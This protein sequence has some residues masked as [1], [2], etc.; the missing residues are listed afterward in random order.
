MNLR[1]ETKDFEAAGSLADELP[2]WGRLPD[3]ECLLGRNGNLIALGQLSP[4][5]VDGRA[6][7]HLDRVIRPL[8]TRPGPTWTTRCGFI[9]TFSAGR[10]ELPKPVTD[11]GEVVRLSQQRRGEFLAGRVSDV[12]VYVAWC[13]DAGLQAAGSEVNGGVTTWLRRWMAQR[14]KPNEVV[15]LRRAVESAAEQFRQSVAASRALVSDLTPIDLLGPQEGSRVLSELVNRPGTPWSGATGGGLNWQLAVSELEAERRFLRLD[16]EAALVYSMLSRPGR[17]QGQPSCRSFSPRCHLD[18][19]PGV[20][21]LGARFRPAKDPQRPKTLLLKALLH[22]RPHAG[23]PGNC[24]RHDRHRRRGGIKPTWQRP[25]RAGGRWHLLRFHHLH[26]YPP[27]RLSPNR[28]A[29]CPGPPHLQHL[30]R[31]GDPRRI[32]PAPGMV[33]PAAR[34][35]AQAAASAASLHPPDCWPAWLQSLE[36]PRADLLA[37][38]CTDRPWLSWKPQPHPLPL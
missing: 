32:R 22:G 20:E 23:N 19:K 38:T 14:K 17:G 5:P 2:Y 33:L 29:R 36:P 13:Y 30:R 34:A 35:A 15:Y 12:S 8:A 24:C 26:R 3:G 4:A 28:P 7:V 27:R 1:E 25:C 31:Q 37:N 18:R 6:P 10:R 11:A 21:A 16:G 9:S